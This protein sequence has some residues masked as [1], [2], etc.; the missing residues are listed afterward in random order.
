MGTVLVDPPRGN[1]LGAGIH[2]PP[3]EAVDPAASLVPIRLH[4]PGYSKQTIGGRS[5]QGVKIKASAT[6]I[7]RSDSPLRATLGPSLQVRVQEGKDTPALPSKP[8]LVAVSLHMP[9]AKVLRGL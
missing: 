8:S 6:L 1:D 9:R 7:W 2:L 3:H 5:L 4:T